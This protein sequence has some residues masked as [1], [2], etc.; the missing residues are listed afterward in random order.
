MSGKIYVNKYIPEVDPE[1]L[2]WYERDDLMKYIDELKYKRFLSD[3]E[4]SFKKSEVVNFEMIYA[5]CGC[6]PQQYSDN[7][8]ETVR[9]SDV[10]KMSQR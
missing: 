7:Y 9:V 4:A 2:P 8:Y 6:A 10:S 1:D 3:P 5:R